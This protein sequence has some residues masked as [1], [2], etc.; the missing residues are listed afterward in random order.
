MPRRR[1]PGSRRAPLGPGLA[2]RRVPQ[3]RAPLP[4]GP[5]RGRA[6]GGGGDR[7]RTRGAVDAPSARCAV[8]SCVAPGSRLSPAPRKLCAEPRVARPPH[9]G[10]RRRLRVRG[11]WLQSRLPF[12]D[13]RCSVTQGTWKFE[14]E[15]RGG[16]KVGR[17]LGHGELV[18]SGPGP[19]WSPTQQKGCFLLN[20]MAPYRGALTNPTWKLLPLPAFRRDLQNP[21][22][23]KHPYS[24]I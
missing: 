5:Q 17:V 9:E 19:G 20:G 24:C 18:Q 22:R 4:G 23:P 14:N 13:E 3:S 21:E 2:R 8:C 1:R 12:P 6:R 7:R 10:R 16:G 15:G 11:L